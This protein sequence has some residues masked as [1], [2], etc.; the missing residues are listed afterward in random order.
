MAQGTLREYCE[1]Q[2]AKFEAC[3]K[4]A[5]QNALVNL[6][7]AQAMQMLLAEIANQESA[8]RQTPDGQPTPTH[9]PKGK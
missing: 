3:R 7:A 2:L 1:Q 6:G 8:A 9:S 4:D 5:E